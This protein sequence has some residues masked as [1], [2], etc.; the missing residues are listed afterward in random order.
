MN[1]KKEDRYVSPPTKLPGNVKSLVIQQWLK[2]VQRD[3]IAGENGLSAGSVTNIVNKW[4][5][6]L[7]FSA[8]DELRELA[9]TLK[10]VGITAAQCAAGFTS[11]NDDVV[12]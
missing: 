3:K 2:G 5:D 9:V 4:R 7:G 8:A 1:C 10:K 6:A 12:D 11:C